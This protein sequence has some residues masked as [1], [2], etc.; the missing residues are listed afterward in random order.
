MEEINQ[1][2]KPHQKFLSNYPLNKISCF[3]GSKKKGAW[4]YYDLGPR[5]KQALVCLHGLAGACSVFYKQA[6]YLSSFGYRV[7]C[8]QYPAFWKISKFK[9][10]FQTFLGELEL[11]RVHLF[12]VGL[13]GFLC[14]KYLEKNPKKVASVVL[15]NSFL[16]TKFFNKINTYGKSIAWVPEFWLKRKLLKTFPTENLLFGVADSVDFM[17][18]IVNNLT[19][20]E[21]ASRFSIL[22]ENLAVKSIDFDPNKVTV[23]TTMDRCLCPRKT[24]LQVA[25]MFPNCKNAQIKFGGEFPHLANY[26]DINLH[27]MVHLRNQ[28]WDLSRNK[29]LQFT[30]TINKKDPLIRINNNKV[31]KNKKLMLE[32][33]SKSSSESGSGSEDEDESE[34]VSED[35]SQ[36]KSE[37]ESESGSE[38]GSKSG[39]TSESTPITKNNNNSF[40]DQDLFVSDNSNKFQQKPNDN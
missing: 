18:D 3:T 2:E 37:S 24:R 17:V 33:K 31:E 32:K 35:E 36:S 30:N 10:I 1:L 6:L 8:A 29:R 4:A 21:L 20:E 5:N 9:R 14:L 39:S 26:D 38:S 16:S 27:L 11:E 34:N 12:G 7:V 13:G 15:C 19:F 22:G 40:E 28:N 25:S 23:I